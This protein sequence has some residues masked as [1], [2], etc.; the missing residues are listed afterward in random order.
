MRVSIV[1]PLHNEADNVAQLVSEIATLSLKSQFEIILVN[2]ASFDETALVLSEMKLK[3]PHLKVISHSKKYGQS[4]AIATGVRY[5]QGELIATLDGDGQNDPA[6]I[7]KLISVLEN[8]QEFSMVAGYRRERHDSWWKIS[9]SKIANLVRGFI[10]RDNTPDA[11]C[12]LKVFYKTTFLALP[13]FDHMHR[14]L[15]ALVQMQGGKVTSVEVSHRTR[16]HGRSN[17]G[18][19]DRLWVGIIDLMGVRWLR[20]RSRKILIE[21]DFDE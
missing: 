19:W 11:G 18:T 2:D 4:A 15:P 21:E 10:L 20:L 5:S 17:Y 7:P 6:D 16:A 9:S 3:I 8:N 1:I 14:F 13:F 12:G